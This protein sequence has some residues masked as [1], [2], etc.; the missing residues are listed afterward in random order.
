MTAMWR[1]QLRVLSFCYSALN[2]GNVSMRRPDSYPRFLQ[3]IQHRLSDFALNKVT[4]EYDMYLMSREQIRE[5]ASGA[6]RARV[7]RQGDIYTLAV[8]SGDVVH[9][10]R[11]EWTCTCAHYLTWRLPCRHVMKVVDDFFNHL[12]LPTTSIQPRWNIYR[13]AVVNAP[14]LRTID[15]LRH[16]KDH[17][18]SILPN[19]PIQVS[20]Q[21]AR[22]RV[23]FKRLA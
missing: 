3:H 9:V 16:I 17:A 2:A 22:C 10:D 18:S 20:L 13:G 8:G 14:L 1:H 21:S 6:W 11:V 12:Q 7:T 5:S 23:H 4:E 15:F 19:Q